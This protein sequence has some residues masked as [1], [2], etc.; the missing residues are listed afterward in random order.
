MG[1]DRYLLNCWGTVPEGI[2]YVNGARTGGDIWADW[3]GMMPAKDATRAWLFTHNICWHADP[4]VICV[5]PPLTLDQARVWASLMGLTGQLLMA[6]DKMYELPEERVELLRRIYPV[7]SMVPMEFYRLGDDQLEIID[8][9]IWKQFR[10]W[11]VVGLFNWGRKDKVI[12][13]GIK[14]LGLRDHNYAVYDFWNRTFLGVVEDQAALAIPKESC[15]VL[16]LMPIYNDRPTLCSTSRHITQGGVDLLNLE[17][18]RGKRRLKGESGTLV[19]GEPYTLAFFLPRRAPR[20]VHAEAEGAE[21]TIKNESDFA[22]VTFLPKEKT[23]LSWFVEYAE[24]L[25]EERTCAAPVP[26]GDAM[27]TPTSLS[28]S[29]KLEG[30]DPPMAFQ[31]SGDHCAAQTVLGNRWVQG[32]LEPET[33]YT[34][35]VTVKPYPDQALPETSSFSISLTTEK[36]PPPPPDPDILLTDLKPISHTQEWGKL[37]IDTSCEGHPLVIGGRTFERG[38]GTHARSEIEYEIQETYEQ[39][40]AYV[41]VDQETHSGSVAFEVWLDGEKVFETPVIYNGDLPVGVSVPVK[42]KR[43]MRLVVTNGGDNINYDHADW[44]NAGFVTTQ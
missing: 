18:E 2:G 19:A 20:I 9:K 25:E 39:F 23:W 16:S 33:T 29:W 7:L 27:V 28:F 10:H 21:V 40:T 34:Y 38:L 24:P 36:L 8:L 41:G 43:R 12:R 31:V 4:D 13:A 22:T 17:L 15:R 5:R 14:E 6:S 42:G 26:A 3:R 37:G 1:P 30:G 35:I 44:A 32:D 11:D